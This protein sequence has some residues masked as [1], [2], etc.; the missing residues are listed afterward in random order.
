MEIVGFRGPKF[1]KRHGGTVLHKHGRVRT[2]E[3]EEREN[4][5]L[6]SGTVVP[7]VSLAR[8]VRWRLEFVSSCSFSWR[9]G[10]VSKGKTL[11]L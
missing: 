4:K 8:F 2:K 9:L 7:R 11:V 1:K 3:R 10:F 6:T 5:K